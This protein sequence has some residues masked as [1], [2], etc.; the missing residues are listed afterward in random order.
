MTADVF[1]VLNLLKK[2]GLLVLEHEGTMKQIWWQEGEVVFA[3]SSSPTDSLGEFLVRHGR[4]T[5]AQAETA[6]AQAG[7]GRRQGRVLVEMGLITPRQLWWAVRNQVLEII[8]AVFDWK[9]GHFRFFD[10]ETL[11]EEKI[12][13][14]VSAANLIMEG[15]RRVDEWPRIRELITGDD[16]VPV[17]SAPMEQAK[18]EIN[19]EP[20]EADLYRLI[21][22][23]RTVRQLISEGELGEFETLGALYTFACAGIVKLGGGILARTSG[24][25]Q[26]IREEELDD[27]GPLRELIEGYEALFRQLFTTLLAHLGSGEARAL[28]N[29]VIAVNLGGHPLVH[30]LKF[31]EDGLL[32][33]NVLLANAAEIPQVRRLADIDDGLGQILSFCLFE[34]SKKLS[35]EHKDNA[36]AALSRV[37]E[38]LEKTR[39]RLLA[40]AAEHG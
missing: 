27:S 17:A 37:R 13:L 6:F 15:M 21:D 25:H 1:A 38:A 22:G 35:R 10:G 3:A 14:A 33:P 31:S 23:R 32:D 8:Y 16:L 26:A 12:Q 11:G 9:R 7:A 19:F 29:R 2:T 28:L 20:H 18:A 40:P 36:F 34:A 39:S 4:I 24:K 30:N 5:R